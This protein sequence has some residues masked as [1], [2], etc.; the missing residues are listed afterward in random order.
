MRFSRIN[1]D[2]NDGMTMLNGVYFYG[3]LQEAIGFDLV[4]IY[5]DDL[6]EYI[7]RE[8]DGM[9]G[10]EVTVDGYPG[11]VLL[12]AWVPCTEY[13]LLHRGLLVDA[14][15]TE[16]IKFAKDKFNEKAVAL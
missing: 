3:K 13:T 10:V 5:E 2:G 15:D 6:P 16:G 9:D 7:A 12:Y 14:S 4:F 11:K 8:M 1:N